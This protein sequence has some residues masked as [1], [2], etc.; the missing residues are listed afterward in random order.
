MLESVIFL[1]YQKNGFSQ[2]IKKTD[3]YDK[4]GNYNKHIIEDGKF[5][6]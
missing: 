5:L 6:K 3:L 2:F 4:F 1:E